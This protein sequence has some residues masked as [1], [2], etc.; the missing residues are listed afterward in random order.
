[1]KF[2]S[3]A[4]AALVAG[5]SASEIKDKKT[6]VAE[7]A[8]G[9]MEA[10]GLKGINIGALLACIGQEDKAALVADAAVQSFEDA[11][12]TKNYEEALAGVFA[13]YAAYQSAVQGL[14]ACEA[15]PTEGW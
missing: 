12:K 15:V 3:L 14:P 11:Y 8:A 6:E 1:M 5:T 10:Y 4:V 7:V 2:T 9:I 13:L